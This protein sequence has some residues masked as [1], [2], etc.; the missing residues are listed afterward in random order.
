MW[1]YC[2]LF[3]FIHLFTYSSDIA[4]VSLIVGTKYKKSVQAGIENKKLYCEMHGYDLI[5]AEKYL[6]PSR[7]IPWSKILLIQKILKNS[8]YKWIFW[9]DADS[10]IM[11]LG[12][13]LEEF[14][15]PNYNLIIG[16]DFHGINTGQFFLKNCP[17][18]LQLLFDIY[19]HIECIHHSWWE[20][21]AL[22][23]EIQDHPELLNMIKIVPQR[24]FNSYST[25]AANSHLRSTYHKGDFILHF[26]NMRN[27]DYLAN[28]FHRYSQEVI[29]CPEYANLDLFLHNAGFCLS[30]KHSK[31]NE[32]YITESQKRQFIT[33]LQLHPHIKKIAEIGLNAGHSAEFFFQNCPDLEQFI[34][35][36]IQKH[37]Y[38]KVA[39]EFLE[40]RYKNRFVFI[41]G[42]SAKKVPE[43]AKAFPLTKCDLI[44]IDGSHSYENV[45]KDIINCKELADET[46][47]L[48]IDDYNDSEVKK[49]VH[50]CHKIGII[51]LLD[52]HYSTDPCGD[53]VWI[54]GCY[55]FDNTTNIKNS[56]HEPG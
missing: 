34:S 23:L 35:F 37:E 46:S 19:A 1:L 9:T 10:L 39:Q 40:R 41:P 28:L 56:D 54:E 38:T 14:L 8:S 51:K 15:D 42:A 5:C 55:L 6:D 36:D 47:I 33:W 20:Q 16:K 13:K 25:E 2:I 26:P 29:N 44:Y 52:V 12:V 17:W 27:L 43:F 48:W 50:K 32:G 21:Q 22:L 49:A 3:L 7:P 30:P 4:V 53:R 31:T 11:N 24:L 45:L 18:S